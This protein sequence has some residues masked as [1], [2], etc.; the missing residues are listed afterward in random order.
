MTCIKRLYYSTIQPLYGGWPLLCP[1]TIYYVTQPHINAERLN[2]LP[3]IKLIVVPLPSTK[4]T[5]YEAICR[6]AT[7]TTGL[8][9][10]L[11]LYPKSSFKPTNYQS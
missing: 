6:T 2:F 7:T 8:L 10:M 4:H 11:K 5:G 1:A 9:N 3:G